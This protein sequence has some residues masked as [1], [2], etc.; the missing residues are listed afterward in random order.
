MLELGLP[1]RRN[2]LKAASAVI[3]GPAVI[4]TAKAYDEAGNEV[5]N[6]ED[7]SNCHIAIVTK[8]GKV[9]WQPSFI[10]VPGT[11]CVEWKL[12]EAMT[13][14]GCKMFLPSIRFQKYT[15]F[16]GDIYVCPGDILKL[17]YTLDA[18]E[19]YDQIQDIH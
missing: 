18:R 8:E 16:S 1:S 13:L 11:V 3:L 7:R 15:K 19:S 10:P 12:Y 14:V 4:K 6:S 5:P 2:F 17:T 9:L